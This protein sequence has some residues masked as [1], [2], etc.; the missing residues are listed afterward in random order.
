MLTGIKVDFNN[1]ERPRTRLPQETPRPQTGKRNRAELSRQLAAS[2]AA[3]LFIFDSGASLDL[4]PQLNVTTPAQPSVQHGNADPNLAEADRVADQR[5][6]LFDLQDSG[7]SSVELQARL[8]LL[9]ERLERL[10]ARVT[11]SDLDTIDQLVRNAEER[12]RFLRGF[13]ERFGC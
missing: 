8:N 5:A 11:A 12:S 10:D 2:A 3:S 1:P 6:R 13:E 9:T 7:K 4:T